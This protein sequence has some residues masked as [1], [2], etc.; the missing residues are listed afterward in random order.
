MCESL[1]K[2]SRVRRSSCPFGD[3]PFT[4]TPHSRGF[5][6]RSYFQL[7]LH[8]DLISASASSFYARA[9]L[10]AINFVIPTRRS[11]IRTRCYI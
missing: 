3:G 5:L 9:L 2:A 6:Q 11:Q 4:V 10:A 7:R 8:F 1:E